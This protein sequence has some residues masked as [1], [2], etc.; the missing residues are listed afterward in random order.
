MTF[1][2][3]LL[4]S[5]LQKAIR[6]NESDLAVRAAKSLIIKDKVQ[7]L[8]RFLVIILEDAILH[9]QYHLIVEM[10]KRVSKKDGKPLTISEKE[11]LLKIVKEVAEIQ[12]VDEW[13]D[14]GWAETN[15][16]NT[17]IIDEELSTAKKLPEEEQKLLWAIFY[18]SKIG[19]MSGDIMMLKFYFKKWLWRFQTNWNTERLKRLYENPRIKEVD[20]EKV[21]EVD[22]DD[23]MLEAVDFHCSPLLAILMRKKGTI[24]LLKKHYPDWKGSWEDLMKGIL[25]KQR[26]GVTV[27]V[28]LE[29]GQRKDWYD[30][31]G[32]GFFKNNN[33]KADE[34]I[35]N[36]LKK[37]IDAISRWFL[38]KQIEKSQ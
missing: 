2:N 10:L 22:I 34:I 28:K 26:S 37:E 20:W 24:E 7:F 35:F 11:T 27:K 33:K 12:W 14:T 38:Y 15:N 32:G 6:R 23:I 36:T 21:K 19:G 8:R 16:I 25:W 3:S 30:I 9:P 18:R 29:T 31:E 4:K 1:S 17:E 5:A 13:M